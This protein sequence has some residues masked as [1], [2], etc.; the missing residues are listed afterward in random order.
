MISFKFLKIALS[1]YRVVG[2]LMPTS[3]YA[4]RRIVSHIKVGQRTVVEYGAG[5]G[6]ITKEILK[7]LPV[8]GKIIAIEL[9]PDLL[10]EL[11][12]IRDSRLEI[13]SGDVFELS[14]VLPQSDVI[15]SG[16]PFSQ[17]SREKKEVII[18][19]TAKAL[20]KG[21]LFIAYQNSPILLKSLK[22]VFLKTK[23]FF[24]PRNIFP[25]FIMVAEK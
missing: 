13:W 2:E 23:L 17:M 24:E 4:V 22:K 15:I 9:N 1:D 14:K 16:V 18:R 6:V 20:N 12:K 19:Q 25:Y 8:N 11:Q 5:D 21:G 3:R 7:V 10:T